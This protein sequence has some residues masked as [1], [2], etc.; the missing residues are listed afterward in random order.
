MKIQIISDLHQEFGFTDLDFSS[1]D[2]VVLAG[3]INLGTKGIEWIKSKIQN[4]P[5]IYVL[6]N[7][8]YYK[9][10]YPKTL[11]KIKAAAENS[12]VFVLENSSVDIDGIRFHGATLWTDFSIFGNPVQYGML[13]QSKMNDYKMIRR[14]PSYSKM[15]TI[16]TFKIHQFS[17]LWLKENLEESAGLKNII[18]T[19]H[20]PS[21]KSVP[22]H[23]SKDPLT[24]AY[25]SDLEDLIMDYEPLYWIHGHIH[26]PCRYKIGATE[27]ICNPHGYIDEKYNGYD[28]ELFVEV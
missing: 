23:Y 24:A 28:K 15:R 13:C 1:A 4:K 10:S 18:V 5:V 8:E 16:D 12:S 2:L 11:N 17:K 7:H 19:H 26:T 14:D 20:A 3:D 25:A 6:G 22:E 9:G 27:V 21:I